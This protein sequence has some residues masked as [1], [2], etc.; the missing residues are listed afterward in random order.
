MYPPFHVGYAFREPLPSSNSV[1]ISLAFMLVVVICNSLK[2]LAIYRTLKQCFP[3]QVILTSSDGV[4]SYVE[5]PDVIALGLCTLE[6]K[7]IIKQ[8]RD[9]RSPGPGNTTHVF[10]SRALENAGFRTCS[11]KWCPN[12]TKNFSSLMDLSVGQPRL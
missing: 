8:I 7:D 1:Q 12:Q 11:C 10:L 5:R 2:V 9:P 4:S 6:R 3:C